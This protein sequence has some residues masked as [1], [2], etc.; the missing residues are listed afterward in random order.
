[1]KVTVRKGALDS[2]PEDDRVDLMAELEK[3]FA[4]ADPKS[5]PGQPV[6][7]IPVTTTACPNCGGDFVEVTVAAGK[8]FLDCNGCDGAFMQVVDA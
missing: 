6:V 7:S 4:N 8:R 5:P 2:I 1:M 3:V